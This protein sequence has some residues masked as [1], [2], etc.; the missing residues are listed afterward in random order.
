MHYIYRITNTINNKIYIGQTN[1]PSLRWS[2]HKSNAKYNR[3]PQIITRAISK[4]GEKLFQFE[5]IVSCKS[6]EDAD[7]IEEE[8]INKYNSLDLSIGYNIIAG[9][10]TTP[11]TPKMLKLISDGLKKYYET[12]DGWN[13]GGTLTEEWKNKISESHIG[14]LG[15]NTGK[16]FNDEWRFKIS[17]S[18]CGKEKKAVRRFTDDQEKEICRL[19]SEENKSMYW[20]GKNFNCERTLINDILYRNNIVKRQSNYTGHSNKRNLFTIEQEL[21]IC[22]MSNNNKMSRNEL[23]KYFKCCKTTI[24]DIL[25][26]HNK[27]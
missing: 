3:C 11:R 12:H 10:N 14:L 26:R 2:Q 21:E 5:V 19:Y 16:T 1:N 22:D 13:K 24:R 20:I 17:K 15:T 4:Y 27:L 6:Q 8:I 18:Q 23:A 9:G 7:F 25:I